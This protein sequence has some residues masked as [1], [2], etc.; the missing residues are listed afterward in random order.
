MAIQMS[1][2]ARAKMKEYHREW[3]RKNKDHVKQYFNEWRRKNKDRVKLYQAAYWERKAIE[4][5]T[6]ESKV[7]DLHSKGKS[8]REIGKEMNLSH[9]TVKRILEAKQ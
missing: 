1:E 4:G 8:L 6:T 3:K 9:M 5:Q 7:I 2:A